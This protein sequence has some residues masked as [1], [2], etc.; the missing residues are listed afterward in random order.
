[1]IRKDLIE[2]LK[3][4]PEDFGSEENPCK[5][6]V[7]SPSSRLEGLFTITDL[8]RIVHAMESLHIIDIN[9]DFYLH[10]M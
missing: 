6:E 4:R 5:V 10:P 9:P 2:R 1:M 3:V 7:D 8:R